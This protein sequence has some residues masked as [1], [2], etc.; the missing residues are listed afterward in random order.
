MIIAVN[1]RGLPDNYPSAYRCFIYETFKRIAGNNPQHQFIFISDRKG[2][3]SF[4]PCSNIKEVVAGPATKHPLLWR[5]WFDI[6]IPSLLRKYKAD[7]FVTCDG[8]CSLTTKVP[9][10]LVLQDVAFLQQGSFMSKS[11]VNFF[12]KNSSKFLNKANAIAATSVFTKQAMVSRYNISDSSIDVIYNAVSESF[13]PT[14]N[15]EKLVVKNNYTEGKEFFLYNGDIHPANNLLHLLKAFSV[16]KKRQQTS[17]KLVL[18]G[19]VSNKYP[20]FKESLKSYKYRKDIVVIENAT[21]NE[22][23]SI[24][25]AAYG[26]VNPSVYEGFIPAV[27]QAMRCNV[28]VI[29]VAGSSMQEITESA[30]LYVDVNSHTDIAN[31]MMLLYKDEKLHKELAEKGKPVAEKFTW[32]KTADLLWQSILKACK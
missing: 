14:T 29:S 20:S 13:Q 5:F 22:L 12:K 3:Y 17:M 9:Q 6:K 28:P 25:G 23:I 4:V 31:K 19:K 27:L 21:E 15:E 26:L 10:C 16:F 24:V 7:V 1:T 30:A 2:E 8:I 11:H 32:D 18:A